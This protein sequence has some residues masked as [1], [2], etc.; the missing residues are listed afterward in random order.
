MEAAV[1]RVSE[2]IANEEDEKGINKTPE[3]DSREAHVV[4]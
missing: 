2:R 4:L 3:P 1:K